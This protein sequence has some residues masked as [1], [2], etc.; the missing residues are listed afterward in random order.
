MAGMPNLSLNNT[1]AA[2]EQQRLFSKGGAELP[3]SDLLPSPE[4]GRKR[5]RK[6]Q[7]LADSYANEGVVV[8]LTVVPAAAYID[9]YPHLRE[10]VEK[11]GKPYVVLAG[12]RRL[13]A[14]E[15]A[16]LEK[17]PVSFLK[18]VPEGGSLRVA[19][20]KENDERLGLDP[21]E[22]GE[23]Y[24]QLLDELNVS[25]RELAKRT[26]V[27]QTA[28]SHK[29]KLLQ[30]IE[31]LQNAVI[32]HWCKQNNVP[33]D[34]GGE[35]LLPIK[36]AATV[37]AGL[38]SDL[39]QAYVDGVLS[40]AG[41]E[42]IVKSKVALEDQQLVT[43]PPQPLPGPP[44]DSADGQTSAGSAASAQPANPA[45]AGSGA[46]GGS[47]GPNDGGE[48]NG[49]PNPVPPPRH[50]EGGGANAPAADTGQG[51]HPNEGAPNPVP[52][53]PA[54]PASTG[55]A[56]PSAAVATQTERGVIPVTTVADIYTGLKQH[57]SPDE[58]EELQ[59]LMLNEV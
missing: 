16:R 14:A 23:Q 43:A 34:F 33:F 12:H 59:E 3:L 21:I 9:H 30:L 44:Q 51:G 45:P 46:S 32:D 17:V 11:S 5:L 58:F 6:V 24:Q 31:P 18:K 50:P 25:Q 39:Q 47:A 20:I 55:T 8:A 54:A 37:L 28:I 1:R 40:L 2:A 4:N 15:L 10:F 29:I 22:E 19:S 48:K 52:P 42:A 41:A 38:R 27:S 56:Q 7:E 49:D 57:L 13:A 35:R 36:E 53:A 26:G